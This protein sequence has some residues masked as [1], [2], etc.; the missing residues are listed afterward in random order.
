MVAWNCT[1]SIYSK[2]SKLTMTVTNGEGIEK[3][4][5]G[6]IYLHTLK[7]LIV[8]TD[9]GSYGSVA[10]AIYWCSVLPEVLNYIILLSRL[11]F[12]VR[13]L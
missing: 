7:N 2:K 3:K 9:D 5:F 8:T 13:L 12:Q 6:R 1:D 11:S 4:Y 10:L